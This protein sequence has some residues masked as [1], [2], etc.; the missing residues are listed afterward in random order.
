MGWTVTG[1]LD[2]PQWRITLPVNKPM[3]HGVDDHGEETYCIYQTVRFRSFSHCSINSSQNNCQRIVCC[4]VFTFPF[5]FFCVRVSFP[6][7]SSASGHQPSYVLQHFSKEFWF[8]SFFNFPFSTKHTQ[9]I[10]VL[11]VNIILLSHSTLALY[12]ITILIS[13]SRTPR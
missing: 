10:K 11:L 6:I 5:P 3:T 2:D 1:L 4:W 9:I 7:S 13:I 12:R 8:N